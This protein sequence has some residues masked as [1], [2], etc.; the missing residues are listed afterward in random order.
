[1]MVI[2]RP[3]NLGAPVMVGVDASARGLA[4]LPHAIRLA[5]ALGTSLQLLHVDQTRAG[6]REEHG[7]HAPLHGQELLDHA[8]GEVRKLAPGLSVSGTLREGRS[9]ATELLAAA[10]EADVLVLGAH[11]REGGPGNTVSAVLHKAPCNVLV[12]R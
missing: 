9:A 7:R 6:G 11:S 4:T 1:L 5:V 2:R 12:T 3:R 8:L 10:S